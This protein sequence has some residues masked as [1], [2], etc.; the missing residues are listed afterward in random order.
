MINTAASKRLLERIGDFASGEALD[1][2]SL[3]KGPFLARALFL[4]KLFF[5][6]LYL[7]P[8]WDLNAESP[9]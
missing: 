3:K 9:A 7:M 1:L 5:S 8:S 2:K 4:W 6:H